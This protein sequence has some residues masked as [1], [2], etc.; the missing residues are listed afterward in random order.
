M[1]LNIDFNITESLQQMFFD[2]GTD[3][4]KAAD[5]YLPVTG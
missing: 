5:I 1:A 3:T 2:K 4:G